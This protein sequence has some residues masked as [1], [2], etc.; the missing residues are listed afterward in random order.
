MRS[1]RGFLTP[2]L[3]SCP[4]GCAGQRSQVSRGLSPP[5]LSCRGSG[6]DPAGGLDLLHLHDDDLHLFTSTG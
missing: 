4:F 2:D 6:G 5:L 1:M 3:M